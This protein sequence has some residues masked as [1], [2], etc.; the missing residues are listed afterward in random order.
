MVGTLSNVLW[1]WYSFKNY[2][3]SK[4]GGNWWKIWPGLIVTWL[5]AAMSLELLDFPP[6]FGL[7]AHALWHA[8]TIAPTVWWYWFLVRD[9]GADEGR[10][11]KLLTK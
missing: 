8:A 11:E 10:G 2:A 6:V 4:K 5:V 3:D 9:A 1:S 7:D